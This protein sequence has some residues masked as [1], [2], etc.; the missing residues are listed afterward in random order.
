MFIMTFLALLGPA[1]LMV[2]PDREYGFGWQLMAMT[3]EAS[4]WNHNIQIVVVQPYML[5]IGL[6]LFSLR[7]V[8]AYQM[9]RYYNGRTTKMNTL[10]V[11]VASELQILVVMIFMGIGQSVSSPDPEAIWTPLFGPIPILFLTGLVIMK[12]RPPPEITTPWQQMEERKQRWDKD[13]AA[14]ESKPAQSS[15]KEVVVGAAKEKQDLA[16]TA[17]D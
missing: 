2:L 1:I 9:V 3:W 16:E 6:L 14:P 4:Y 13:A 8:F 12:L 15:S 11:G 10:L 5:T 17:E 7:P